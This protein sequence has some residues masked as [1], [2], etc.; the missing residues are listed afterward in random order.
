M[1]VEKVDFAELLAELA[2]TK[3]LESTKHSMTS[4]MP[5]RPIEQHGL[6]PLRASSTTPSPKSQSAKL[7]AEGFEGPTQI[8]GNVRIADYTFGAHS[9]DPLVT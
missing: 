8:R 6:Q 2:H 5:I 9:S 4:V 1:R 7:T 3:R